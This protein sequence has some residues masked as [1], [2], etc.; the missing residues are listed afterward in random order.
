MV[1][2]QEELNCHLELKGAYDTFDNNASNPARPRLARFRRFDMLIAAPK[3]RELNRTIQHQRG[4]LIAGY[5]TGKVYSTIVEGSAIAAI[6][7]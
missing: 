1:R 2:F 4:A 6:E 3:M 5:T 7:V